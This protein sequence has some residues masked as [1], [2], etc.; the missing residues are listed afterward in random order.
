MTEW[1]DCNVLAVQ[2][3]CCLCGTGEGIIFPASCQRSWCLFGRDE[4]ESSVLIYFHRDR[5]F[6]TRDVTVSRFGLVV[7]LVS[8]RA[9][10]RFRF[11]SPLSS[12]VVV[13]G[14]CLVT[15]SL[16]VN[17][18]LKWLSSL[19]FLMQESFWW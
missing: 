6:V 9:S 10:V 8:G 11:G 15:L 14:H 5:T 7:R 17:E 12:E 16:T 18:T 19:P 1:V 4:F 13:C 2:R 3:E